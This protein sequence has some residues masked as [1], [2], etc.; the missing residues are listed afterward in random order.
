MSQ[1]DSL[2]GKLEYGKDEKAIIEG[3]TYRVLDY[4]KPYLAKRSPGETVEIS[5]LVNKDGSKS[6]TKVALHKNRPGA[7]ATAPKRVKEVYGVLRKVAGPNIMVTVEGVNKVYCLTPLM[8][9]RILNDPLY[10]TPQEIGLTADVNNFVLDFSLGP[11][12]DEN[13]LPPL[14]L[15]TK[16]GAEIKKENDERK[17][18]IQEPDKPKD[19]GS[20]IDKP[21]SDIKTDPK[22]ESGSSQGQTP[23]SSESCTSPLPGVSG[24][25][26]SPGK[27][28]F[29]I[30][31]TINFE[32]FE[33]LKTELE[34]P[35]E[36]REALIKFWD[37]TLAL[38]GNKA[39]ATK[40]I[41][42]AYRRRVIAG[43]F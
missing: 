18:A 28:T 10:L 23:G 13:G 27:W 14:G 15:P 6:L 42:D 21:A 34:G 9:D 39:P 37:E 36:D 31:G 4:V 17:A 43:A 16:T 20:R 3:V 2:I 30:G 29:R 11:S 22:N 32:S 33:N 26:L 41:I 7:P 5:F 35:A 25:I 19:E 12:V 40:A 38:L 24:L 1:T 8:A